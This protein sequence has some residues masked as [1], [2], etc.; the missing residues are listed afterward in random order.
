V[1]HV[2][3]KVHGEVATLLLDR[4]AVHNSLSPGLLSDL[5]LAFSDVHQ[6]KRVRAVVLTGAGESFCSGIDIKTLQEIGKLDDTDSMAQCHQYW[7]QWAETVEQILRFPKPIIAAVDGAAIGAGL[8]LALS[9]DL[10]VATPRATFTAA[11]PHRGL[12]GGITT[13]LLAFRAGG[14]LAARWTLTGEAMTCDQALHHG[15]VADSVS[16]D[17]IWVAATNWAARCSVGSRQSIQATKRILNETVGEDL[18]SQIAAASAD[19]ATACSTEAA[20][21]GIDAFLE[22]RDPRWP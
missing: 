5:Q 2:E 15:L 11:A 14:S 19:S 16:S 21:E 4:P 18:L 1:Q 9:A 6:E 17:Q 10:I 7:R 13:A 3:V 12:V 8:A 22:K 20:G